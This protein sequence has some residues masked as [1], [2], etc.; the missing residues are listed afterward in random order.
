MF[1]AVLRLSR[2]RDGGAA[3]GPQTDNEVQEICYYHEIEPGISPSLL[4]AI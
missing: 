2:A 3:D 4:E 1:K